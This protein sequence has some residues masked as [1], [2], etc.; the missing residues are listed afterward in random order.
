MCVCAQLCLTLRDPVDCS[1]PHSSVHG[2][3]QARI[4]E[5]VALSF[6]RGSSPTQGSNLCLLCLLL[7]LVDSLPV[8]HLGTPLGSLPSRNSES[9]YGGGMPLPGHRTLD[10]VVP[11]RALPQLALDR[12]KRMDL[13]QLCWGAGRGKMTGVFQHGG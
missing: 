12:Q 2:I 4:P 10:S 6:S 13:C 9:L 3:F 5:R 1:L 8:S 7:W 11:E